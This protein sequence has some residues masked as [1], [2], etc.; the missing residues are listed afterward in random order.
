MRWRILA[1]LVTTA[2]AACG[3]SSRADRIVADETLF[4]EGFTTAVDYAR[5]ECPAFAEA[6]GASTGAQGG[7]MLVSARAALSAE[8]P[9]GHRPAV[10]EIR[11]RHGQPDSTRVDVSWYDGLGFRADEG[12]EVVEIVVPCS[13]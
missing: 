9:E 1:W 11:E 8:V 4:Y 10:T 3:G 6:V 5:S 7:D 2:V 12:G 13:E